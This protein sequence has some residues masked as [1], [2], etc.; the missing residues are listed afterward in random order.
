MAGFVIRRTTIPTTEE[1]LAIEAV[2]VIDLA[3]PSPATGVGSGN[4]LCVGEFEDGGFAAGGDAP[5]WVGDPGTLEVFSSQD[6]E[7]RFGSF[8]YISDSTSSTWMR[9]SSSTASRSRW[10]ALPKPSPAKRFRAF[11]AS[12]SA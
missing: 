8:G 2:N 5:E 12:R 10:Q 4:V 1:L 6:L 11:T 3:P 7:N 9:S